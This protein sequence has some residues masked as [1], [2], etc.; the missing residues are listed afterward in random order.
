MTGFLPYLNDPQ[1]KHLVLRHDVDHSLE[2]AMRIARIDAEEGCPATFFLRV[3]AHGYNV[4]SY[5]SLIHIE[6]LHRLGHEIELHLDGGLHEALSIGEKEAIDRQKDLLEAALCRPIN[7]FSAHEPTRMG[8]L[9]VSDE[10][11]ERWGIRYHAYQD[12][13]MYPQVK[14]LSDSSARW[15]EGHFGEWVNRADRLQVLVH[16]IWWFDRLPQENI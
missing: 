16:P 15:R 7:G 4:T 12:R 11:L 2:Q 9:G 3:H 6:E 5:Q 8:N 14:Y 13:F 10:A 1:P